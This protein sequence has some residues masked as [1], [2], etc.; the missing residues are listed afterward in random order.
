VK[1]TLNEETQEFIAK[2]Y[3]TLGTNIASIG[4]ASFFFKD[5]PLPF[6]IIFAIVSIGFMIYSVFIMAK[7]GDK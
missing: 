4:I 1:I 6:R 2:I 5:M 7:K 3:C